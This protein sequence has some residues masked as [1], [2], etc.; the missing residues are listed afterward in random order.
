MQINVFPKPVVSESK[1]RKSL[2]ALFT[3]CALDVGGCSWDGIASVEY[4]E[5]SRAIAGWY[6]APSFISDVESFKI[7]YMM[8]QSI[9]IIMKSKHNFNA[10]LK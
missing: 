4:W 9:R 5:G 3:I 10:I 6:V 8:F 2:C 7:E 1:K